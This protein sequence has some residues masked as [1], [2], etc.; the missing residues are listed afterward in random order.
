M[1]DDKAADPK[2]PKADAKT[3]P[4]PAAAPAAEPAKPALPAKLRIVQAEYGFYEEGG[5][6]RHWRGGDI[7]TDPAEIALLI[8]RKA[9]AVPHA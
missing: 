3:A 1:P 7:V 6:Y 9:P 8:A 5:R 4:A 2:A